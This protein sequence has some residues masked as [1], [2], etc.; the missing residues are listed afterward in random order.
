MRSGP[1]QCSITGGT[2]A[3]GSL[4]ARHL[5]ERHGVRSLLLLSRRGEAAAGAADLAAELARLGA[6]ARF[7]AADAANREELASALAGIPADRPLSAVIHTAGVLDDHVLSGLDAGA[8]RTVFA[9]KADA[10]WHLHELTRDADLRAF[11]MFSSIAGI[12]GNPGQANYAAANTYLDGLAWHRHGLGLPAVSLA[13]SLW[14]AAVTGSASDGVTGGMAGGDGARR[15]RR[16]GIEPL[17]AA[18]GLALLDA[19]LVTNEPVLVPAV[20]DHVALAGLAADGKLPA[21]LRG[22]VRATRRAAQ[23]ARSGESAG[24]AGRL[25]GL[26]ADDRE[27]VVVDLVRAEAAAVLG[28]SGPE[29]VRADQAFKDVGFDSLAAVE[30]RNRLSAVA[31]VRLPATLIF[32]YP[33]PAA[34]AGLLLTHVAPET[35][36]PAADSAGVFLG[37][38]DRLERSA[39][40]ANADE[41]IRAQVAARLRR[42]S[43]VW[44]QTG[45]GTVLGEHFDLDAATD[46]D[47]FDLMD[48]EFGRS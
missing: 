47:L 40:R 21:L 2:G 20:F 33:T 14:D 41:E 23:A 42:L 6:D 15:G 43:S 13:W 27:R 26:G 22:R 19:A 4:V 39:A 3:L 1:E 12:L 38:L 10:A 5:A 16:S 46:Q 28:G 34:L 30:L 37:E 24:L 31:G 44:E 35:G 36:S 25:A 9:P 48:N 11:V 32:D 45:P 18:T 17:T 29:A 8:L 7:A